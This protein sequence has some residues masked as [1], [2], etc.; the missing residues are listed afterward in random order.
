MVT[1]SCIMTNVG[2]VLRFQSSIDAGKTPILLAQM[3][4]LEGGCTILF[5]FYLSGFWAWNA[6]TPSILWTYL[7][8]WG[9]ID[10]KQTLCSQGHTPAHHQSQGQ[11]EETARARKPEENKA[12]R[13]LWISPGTILYN[14]LKLSLW[15]HITIKDFKM[16]DLT[17]F[18]Q[19]QLI[20]LP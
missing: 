3:W 5:Y 2:T 18:H 9:G 19:L 12:G 16:L 11:V 14:R 15:L 7:W 20:Q 13:C 8:E 4:V 17:M 10:C 6:G 1:R